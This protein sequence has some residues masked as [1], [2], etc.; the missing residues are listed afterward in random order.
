MQVSKFYLDRRP[1]DITLH[2]NLQP[3]QYVEPPPE[4]DT[5]EIGDYIEVQVGEYKGK[6]GFVDW[7]HECAAMLWVRVVQPTIADEYSSGFGPQIIRVPTSI[8]QRAR[9]APTIKFT[10]D[11][12]YDVTPGDIVS[13]ARG[14][15]YLMQGVVESVD[16]VTAHLVFRSDTDLSSVS[17]CQFQINS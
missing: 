10:K 1:L 2:E 4:A 14:P 5:I 7:Q 13:V 12:G 8:V 11:R 6:C 15:E 3:Q 9:I 16:L 17:P